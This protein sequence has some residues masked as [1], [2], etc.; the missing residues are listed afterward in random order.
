MD[1]VITQWSVLTGAPCSGKTSVLRS[2]QQEGY[3][4]RDEC[5]RAYFDEELRKGRKLEEICA[6]QRALQRMFLT[7]GL[8]Q[9]E[10]LDPLRPYVLDRSPVDAIAHHMLFGFERADAVQEA[11]R[12]RYR[13]VFH[14]AALPFAQDGVR[15]E[16]VEQAAELDRCFAAAYQELGYDIIPVPFMSIV[17]R[18]ALVRSHLQAQF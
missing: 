1:R 5:S 16:T 2:L 6:N 3:P 15:S 18:T 10:T 8:E 17:R 11:S 13:R 9:D 4:V 14:F 7:L 12:F